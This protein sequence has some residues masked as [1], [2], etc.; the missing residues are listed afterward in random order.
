MTRPVPLL[1]S[2]GRGSARLGSVRQGLMNDEYLLAGFSVFQQLTRELLDGIV[3]GPQIFDLGA[4]PR[5]VGEHLGQVVGEFCLLVPGLQDGRKP[6][7]AHQ[8]VEQQGA[9]DEQKRT[10]E[11]TLADRHTRRLEACG[12]FLALGRWHAVGQVPQ[13]VEKYK[14][15]GD[16]LL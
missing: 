12:G 1:V 16:S 10:F 7:A 11:Q 5:V 13:T 4:E 15:D 6:L 3:V 8:H 14:S 2:G 9:S